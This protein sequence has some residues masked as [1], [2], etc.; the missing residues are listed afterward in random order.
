VSSSLSMAA[1][2]SGDIAAR[3][4]PRK[5]GLYGFTQKA[6][7]IR[8]KRVP[9]GQRRR[10]RA[11]RAPE[12]RIPDFLRSL[13]ERLQT[14]RSSPSR[15]FS[16]SSREGRGWT[17]ARALSTPIVESGMISGK[18]R[19][20]RSHKIRARSSPR[21]CSPRALP[22]PNEHRYAC[23]SIGEAEARQHVPAVFRTCR[24]RASIGVGRGGGGGRRPRNAICSSA[25][26][27]MLHLRT[28]SL[29]AAFPPR[30]NSSR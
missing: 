21:L 8:V 3:N 29:A 23:I 26:R 14:R 28:R 22:R 12:F 20:R 19:P 10:R 6:N 27:G 9:R 5:S 17:D 11:F 1:A 25:A 7:R 18:K 4:Q 24:M 30:G 13:N 2:T 15:F 16:V